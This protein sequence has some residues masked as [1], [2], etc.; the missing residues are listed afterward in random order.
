MK[1]EIFSQFKTYFII[2]SFQLTLNPLMYCPID[3]TNT[4]FTQT[5]RFWK[6]K[7]YYFESTLII[8]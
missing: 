6:K 4:R 2:I 5:Y 3:P 8:S 1:S 7:S